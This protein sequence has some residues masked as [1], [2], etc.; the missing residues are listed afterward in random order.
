LLQFHHADQIA[1]AYVDEGVELRKAG[2]HLP[3]MVMNTEPGQFQPLIDH[4]LEPEIYSLEIIRM[5]DSFLKKEG[6][7]FFPVHLK[8][9]TGMHRLGLSQEDLPEFLQDFAGSPS[10]RIKTIFT[11]LVSSEDP[12]QDDFTRKQLALFDEMTRQLQQGLGY[13]SSRHA[14]NTAAITRHP[15]AAFEMVRLG[16]G[17]YGIDTTQVLGE[18]KEAVALKTTI[19]QIRRVKAGE[20]VG[21]GRHAVLERDSTIATI[22][23]GYAD[24]FPRSLGNGNGQVWIAG[25]MFPTVGNVC[26]DMTMIDITGYEKIGLHDEVVVF[27]NENPLAAVAKAAKTI[28]YEIM[29]GISQRVPRIYF[30]E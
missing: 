8:L 21:Y 2:I 27:G 15:N 24:G 7:R 26:M 4:D 17:L 23:I 13:V 14:A 3:I 28:P 10:F 16:I 18:L 11:H 22:R 5:L 1:V 20:A 12:N 9:D 6:I 19:A 29:T 25:K 30:T